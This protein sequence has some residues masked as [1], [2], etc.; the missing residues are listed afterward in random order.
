MDL[1][2]IWW[3]SSERPAHSASGSTGRHRPVVPVGHNGLT[4]S[5]FFT[6]LT[7]SFDLAALSETMLSFCYCSMV[8]IPKRRNPDR[9]A[10]PDSGGGSAGGSVAGS[11][12]GTPQRQVRGRRGSRRNSNA[13][14][15]GEGQGHVFADPPLNANET[16]PCPPRLHRDRVH[17]AC[18]AGPN[19]NVQVE[20]LA[21]DPRYGNQSPVAIAV[22]THGLLL[23]YHE[24]FAPRMR[25][26]ANQG[27]FS[28]SYPMD[29]RKRAVD[30]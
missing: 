15:E 20:G 22:E 26:P 8:R 21:I 25:P 7:F 9:A 11:A 17:D 30:L 4:P 27:G 6:I 14:D 10:R 23:P 5:R 29:Y 12:S 1:W 24:H 3:I 28:I 18:P 19:A 13:G 2:S 16:I